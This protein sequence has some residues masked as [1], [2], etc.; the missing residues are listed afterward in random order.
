[1]NFFSSHTY[2]KALLAS[3][4]LYT[5]WSCANIGN[6]EGGPYDMTP[7][8]LVKATPDNRAT[9]VSDVRMSLH[10]DEYVKLNNQ[11]EKI[12]ISPPQLKAPI[13]SAN[14]K[15]IHIRM[16][17]SLLPETT[18]S[19]YFDDAVVDNNEDNPLTNFS[20][21]FST[22]ATIDSMQISGVVLDAQTLE[23]VSALIVGAHYA[24]G[25]SDTTIR[26]SVP[27]FATR[28]DKMGRFTLRGLKDSTYRVFAL[29]DVDNNYLYN[30][31]TEGIAVDQ[32]LHR[33]SLLD[34]I[35]TDTIRIDSI[36]R[37]DTL[38]RDSLV[39]MAHT[40]YYPD[41]L[42]LRYATSGQHQMGLDRAERI[43]SNLLR[44]SFL[45]RPDTL[46][47]LK[48][49]DFP[50]RSASQVY[51]PVRSQKVVDYW[52]T[53][54]VM[55]GMDSLRFALSYAKTDSLGAVHVQTDSLTLHK[56]RSR[57]GKDS[58]TVANPFRLS[59]AGAKGLVATTPADSLV[60][61]MSLPARELT[62]RSMHLV[63][64]ADSVETPISFGLEQLSD[65]QLSYHITFP[66]KYGH[67]YKLTIDSAAVQSIYGHVAIA[68]QYEQKIA[69]EAEL[70]ALEVSLINAQPNS[71]VQLLDKSG[72][73]LLTQLVE[74][75]P[76]DS[77]QAD[78]L[79]VERAMVRFIDL[80]PEEYYLRMYVDADG[81][82]LW[83]AGTYPTSAP[84]MMYYSPATYAVKKSFTT[85]EEWKVGA[86]PL[87][88]QKP[89]NLRKAKPEEVKKR[90]DKNI[91][92]YKTQESK[93][94]KR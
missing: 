4:L 5:L 70:G 15:S 60:L 38:Y 64:I 57:K 66:R 14:G 78:S 67:R 61:S 85:A 29:Q 33:T 20:Y 68:Q 51:V 28:T 81:D 58:N 37:R 12:L 18:Y 52:L 90:E 50:E 89:Q 56:P 45:S 35:K 91:E 53:D 93:K 17:D 23:P 43:D 84:E 73:P 39:T 88:Q 62:E 9:G 36:V 69:N 25:Y 87:S 6:P 86:L 21:T 82:G 74:F 48:S 40:Y 72:E 26:H 83:S 54:S 71:Y 11:S 76:A 31:P 75:V 63:E 3:I 49:L 30:L 19:I 80:K 32:L 65:E 13:I 8:R 7:P 16:Q 79:A 22:G 41:H 92:Y 55:I 1:M 44:L 42:V 47:V 59:I 10:F 77:T 24:Q 94:K 34:S 27:R 2:A 46:P